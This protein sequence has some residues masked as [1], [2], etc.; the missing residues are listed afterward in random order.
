MLVTKKE[1]DSMKK[2]Y[3]YEVVFACLSGVYIYANRV[4]QRYFLFN[5]QFKYV[6]QK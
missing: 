3:I 6:E 1:C 2:K 5:E 4:K